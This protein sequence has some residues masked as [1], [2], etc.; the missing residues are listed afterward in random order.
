[1]KKL[2]VPKLEERLTGIMELSIS[3]GRTLGSSCIISQMGRPVLEILRG[4]ATVAGEPLGK[5]HIYRLASMT[6]NITGVALLQQ[7]EQH[8]FTLDTKVSDFFPGF[9]HKWIGKLN[10]D[11]VAVPHKKS[12]IP[13]TIKHLVTHTNGL[14]SGPVSQ[15][16][17]TTDEQNATTASIVDFYEKEA[18]LDFEPG[19]KWAYSALGA[20][21]VMCRIVEILSNMPYD[22]YVK[23]HITGPLGM[24]DTVFLPSEEQI[25]RMVDVL[26]HDEDGNN[27]AHV[28]SIGRVLFLTPLTRFAGGGGM[29]STLTD[30][31]KFA[32]MLRG[33]GEY[34]GVRILSQESVKLMRTPHIPQ[35]MEGMFH[36]SMTFGVCCL[37][38]KNSPFLHDNCYGWGGMF[39]THT[40]V[41]PDNQISVVWMKNSLVLDTVYSPT[42][43]LAFEKAV[44][45]SLE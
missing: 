38:R 41:D 36:P 1:M 14:G 44:S 32:E 2:N 11:G 13:M 43:D 16:Q 28:P 12:E 37:V 31:V 20:F 6:K 22:E 23:R 24:P 30:Y 7:M 29:C 17:P 42:G 15:A 26:S 18:L 35:D 9:A 5:N 33:E 4:T 39:G 10:E 40:W 25:S 21:D 8:K 34:S 3:E 19:A 27:I 45:E